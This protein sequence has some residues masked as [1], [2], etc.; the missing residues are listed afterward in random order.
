MME[1]FSQQR[2]TLCSLAM[3]CYA[4]TRYTSTKY[5]ILLWCHNCWPCCMYVMRYARA[6]CTY[7]QY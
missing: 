6:R 1:A 2:Y 5:A 3:L 7:S 4:S